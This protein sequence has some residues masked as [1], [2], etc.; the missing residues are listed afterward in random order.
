M[1]SISTADGTH[2]P[3]DF[4]GHVST[5]QLL[6]NQTVHVPNL[7]IN[8]VSVGQLCESRLICLFSPFGCVV[9][10][11]RTKETLGIGRR[12]GRMFEVIYLRLPPS[13]SNFVASTSSLSSFDI[14]H[15]RLGHISQS[16][17]NML[18][19]SG[20]LRTVKPSSF[21][22][23]ICELGK[24]HALPFNANEFISSQSFDLIHSDVWDQHLIQLWGVHGILLYLLMIVLD[25]LGFI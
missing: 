2:I 23:I 1:Q 12:V 24:H 11:P 15:A 19:Q 21:S 3:I 9:Q 7:S 16:R 5:P 20:L 18:V 6:L 4:S 10:D 17:L 25:L 14:W 22:C 13:S 8:L